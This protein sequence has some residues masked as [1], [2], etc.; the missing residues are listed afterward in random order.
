MYSSMIEI[1]GPVPQLD[2]NFVPGHQSLP[3]DWLKRSSP[4]SQV[5]WTSMGANLYPPSSMSPYPPGTRPQTLPSFCEA[6]LQTRTGMIPATQRSL[7]KPT[8]ISANSTLRMH[9]YLIIWNDN[10]QES[11]CKFQENDLYGGLILKCR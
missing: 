5:C 1:V 7:H 2:R 3:G 8:H 9:T 11:R 10:A 6:Q 4:S